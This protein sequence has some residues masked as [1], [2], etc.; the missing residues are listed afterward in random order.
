MVRGVFGI[1]RLDGGPLAGMG[2]RN[3]PGAGWGASVSLAD[4]AGWLGIAGPDHL[5][6]TSVPSPARLEAPS[7]SIAAYGRIDD[8][9]GL[10]AALGLPGR[11]ARESTTRDLLAASYRKWGAALPAHVLGDWQCAIWDPVARRLVLA[12]GPGDATNL[13]YAASGDGIAFA[14]SLPALTALTGRTFTVDEWYVAQILTSFP[15]RPDQTSR[16]G[17]SRLPQGHTLVADAAGQRV[18]SH[19]FHIPPELRLA[20]PRDYVSGLHEV[21]TQAVADRLVSD[22]RVGTMLSGGLD[23]ATVA[24]F[25]APMITDRGKTLAAFTHGPAFVDWHVGS[26]RFGDERALSAVTS[27]GLGIRDH[28]LLDARDVSPLTVVRRVLAVLGAP[29]HAA[30]NLPWVT[31][32]QAT[33]RAHGIV[34]LFTGSAGNYSISWQGPA[35]RPRGTAAV[36]A[37]VSRLLRPG[38]DWWLRRGEPWR[39]YSAIRADAARRL[40]LGD[41]MA[42]AGHDPLFRFAGVESRAFR[43]RQLRHSCEV[44]AILGN[45]HDIVVVDP[46]ADPRVVKY[47]LSVPDAEY[48]GP[49]GERRWLVRRLMAG[50]LPAAVLGNQR[51]GRQAADLVP[52]LRADAEAMQ[53]AL[54]ECAASEAACALV[55]VPRLRETWRQVERRSTPETHRLASSVLLRGLMAGLF[56]A[57]AQRSGT[58]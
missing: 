41:R 15:P 26:T 32:L 4:Q 36:R 37:R 21:L 27:A 44:R 19:E 52:R 25:L 18:T 48:C 23:S 24:W 47:C 6:G 43:L 58:G 33:A 29:A 1:I 40:A 42:E 56:L 57:Q 55:D 54:T 45:A 53:Q 28:H 35:P 49:N 13:V 30:N 39:P 9:D 2:R 5:S 22:A 7:F 16:L 31:D 11:H 46:T 50:R 3:I 17:V 34:T 38:R 12:A 20:D 10:V 8:R 14:P 51:R